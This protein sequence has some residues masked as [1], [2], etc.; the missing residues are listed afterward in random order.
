MKRSII[1]FILIVYALFDYVLNL[2]MTIDDLNNSN[3]EAFVSKLGQIFEN[4]PWV[5]REAYQ[6]KPFKNVED[7]FNAMIQVLMNSGREKQLELIHAHPNLA[8]HDML[9]GN[10]SQFST[11]EQ[12]NAGL[13]ILTKQQMAEFNSLNFAYKSRFNFP[14]ILALRDQNEGAK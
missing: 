1:P 3:V 7:L 9:K 5:A 12:A 11:N 13:N 6:K 8:G 14:F 4:S 2:S 10:L